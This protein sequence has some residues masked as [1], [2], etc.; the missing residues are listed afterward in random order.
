[1]ARRS[2]PLLFPL[3]ALPLALAALAVS[4][5]ARA[6]PYRLDQLLELARRN[7]PGLAAGALQT[8][9]VEGQLSEANRSWMP[10]GELLSVLAPA[11]DIQ[12]QP[13]PVLFPGQ[14][15]PDPE[16]YCIHTNLSDVN[17]A[18][19]KTFRGVFSRS[20]LKL[21]QPL[22]TFGKISAGKQAARRGLAASKDREA[23]LRA[24]VEL[25]VKRAYYGLK[26][27]RSVLETL[28]EGMGHLDDAQ[29]QVDKELAEGTGSVTQ[30]DKLR[31]RTVRAELEIRMLEAQKGA[32]EARSGLRALL[33]PEA[34]DDLE[35]DNDPLEEVNVPERP[36]LHYEEQARLYRPEVSALDNLALSKRSL[37]DL[38]RR[39]QYPDLVVLA[40]ASYAYTSSIDNPKNAFLS[41]PFNTNGPSGALALALRLPLD[42]GVRNAR[43]AQ[44]KA[45]ADEANERR[46]EALGGIAYEVRKA[47]ASLIEATK[48]LAIVRGGERASKAWVTAVGANFGAG[49]AEARDFSDAL[50]ASFQFRVRVLQTVHDVN[51]AAAQLTRATGAEVSI[52]A[53]A[54]EATEPESPA[55][56]T[57]AQTSES[58]EPA[59]SEAPAKPAGKPAKPA[60]D[61]K[62]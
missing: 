60:S 21:V 14:I 26:F 34:P 41:D 22:F 31:L 18:S 35:I 4:P 54:S 33:G 57:P 29:K 25:N 9:K 37:A 39:K 23:G 32:D 36:A 45:E 19:T 44:V 13:W 2:R 24:D 15:S 3:L 12:C 46:R 56:P 40:T 55:A 61:T 48:R 38:E 6:E 20:E 1:M 47:H 58:A 62:K 50:V 7:N 30:T 53:K 11:P 27:A 51:I 17:T 49:L 10:T 43:A 42:L 28:Q 52:P 16:Q 8:A 59:E 5:S